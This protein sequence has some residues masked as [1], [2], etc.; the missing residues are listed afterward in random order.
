[1]WFFKRHSL[2]HKIEDSISLLQ[3][4]FMLNIIFKFQYL[5]TW[6]VSAIITGFPIK[7]TSHN[8]SFSRVIINHNQIKSSK[9]PFNSLRINE[10]L[11]SICRAHKEQ[12]SFPQVT[13]SYI[14]EQWGIKNLS[15]TYLNNFYITKP[16]DEIHLLHQNFMQHKVQS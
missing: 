6:V 12:I 11:C 8:I 9:R 5:L 1:M 2:T 16:I 15:Y 4:S 3:Q 14:I 7:Y 10:Y 13:S